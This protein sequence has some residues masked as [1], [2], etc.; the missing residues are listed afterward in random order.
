MDPI[1]FVTEL[2]NRHD[3]GEVYAG[4]NIKKNIIEDMS[5]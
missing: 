5:K 2:R 3:A 1:V 4:L